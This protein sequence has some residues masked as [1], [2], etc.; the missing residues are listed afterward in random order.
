METAAARRS[1]KRPSRGANMIV[2]RPLL[3]ALWAAAILVHPAMLTPDADV[4][5]LAAHNLTRVHRRRLFDP[6][7]PHEHTEDLSCI[8]NEHCHHDAMRCPN[9]AQCGADSEA[10]KCLRKWMQQAL[11]VRP[12]FLNDFCDRLRVKDCLR[13]ILSIKTCEAMRVKETNMICTP[14]IVAPP[15]IAIPGEGRNTGRRGSPPHRPR[16]SIIAF[17]GARDYYHPDAHAGGSPDSWPRRNEHPRGGNEW[18]RGRWAR[19][20]GGGMHAGSRGVD[21]S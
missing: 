8:P 17:N 5:V 20:K 16:D 10:C 2:A 4:N 14:H 11:N 12:H 6:R 3:P 21:E 18:Q 15:G 1:N 7:S 9:P 19:G 13:R